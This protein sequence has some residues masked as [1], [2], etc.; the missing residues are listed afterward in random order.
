MSKFDLNIMRLHAMPTY[1]QGSVHGL[2]CYCV[3]KKRKFK[4][5]LHAIF[6]RG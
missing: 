6:N 5:L 4:Y 1:S 2:L 3:S